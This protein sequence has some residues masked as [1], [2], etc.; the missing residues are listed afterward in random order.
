[1]RGDLSLFHHPSIGR[2]VS[3]DRRTKDPFKRC[4]WNWDALRGGCPHVCHLTVAEHG[5]KHWCCGA[6]DGTQDVVEEREEGVVR[7][8]DKMET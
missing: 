2:T 5:D 3:R 6:E 1:M 7:D 4:G 8:F